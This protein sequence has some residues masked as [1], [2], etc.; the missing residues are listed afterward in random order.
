MTG[1]LAA[2]RASLHA[3]AEHV[4]CAARY[5]A[6]GRIGL[7]VVPGGFATQPFDDDRR[8]AVIGTDVVVRV[9]AAERRARITT[10]RAAASLAG[11]EPGA[12]AQVFTPTTDI[13]PDADPV[14]STPGGRP[15]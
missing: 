12:P 9:D 11:I 15:G 8:V 1:D 3:L 7:Q 2:T 13:D 10:L 6:I 4:L 5:Q 14:R